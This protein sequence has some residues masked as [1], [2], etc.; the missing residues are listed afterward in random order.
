MCEDVSF[1]P[2]KVD[3]WWAV[4]C[5]PCLVGSD[6]IQKPART[7]LEGCHLLP[8]LW[9]LSG[10]NV[11]VINSESSL[12]NC[13]GFVTHFHCCIFCPECQKTWFWNVSTALMEHTQFLKGPVYKIADCWVSF[14]TLWCGGQP[15]LLTQR[16][17]I[18]LNYLKLPESSTYLPYCTAR[19]MTYR[20]SSYLPV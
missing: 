18:W 5:F 12:L 13:D 10:K 17:S 14:P 20:S 15:E 16:V 4:R 3:L 1:P 19:R 11:F 7:G 6:V 8:W 9:S 2:P